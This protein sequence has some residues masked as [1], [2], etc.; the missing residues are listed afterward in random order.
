MKLLEL[1]EDRLA[2]GE[3]P[4]TFHCDTPPLYRRFLS[5]AFSEAQR[6]LG[7]RMYAAGIDDG[8]LGAQIARLEKKIHEAEVGRIPTTAWEVE[9]KSLFLRLAA[10]AMEEDAPLPG[11]DTEYAAVRELQSLLGRTNIP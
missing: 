2:H 7:Q 11:A 5:M 10:C 4:A 3:L 6:R 1:T 9:R 8:E